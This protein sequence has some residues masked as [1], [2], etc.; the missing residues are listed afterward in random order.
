MMISVLFL[1]T[2]GKP[3]E[4]IRCQLA[5]EMTRKNSNSKYGQKR[6]QS[7]FGSETH[8][9]LRIMVKTNIF[10][11]V[12]DHVNAFSHFSK[13]KDVLTRLNLNVVDIRFSC[14]CICK[15]QLLAIL[16]ASMFTSVC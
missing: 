7:W 13:V 1:I 9:F 11:I 10:M 15:Q 14:V 4:Q 2:I 12:K 16:A 6:K 8:F 3:F 5:L